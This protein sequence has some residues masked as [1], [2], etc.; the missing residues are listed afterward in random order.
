MMDMGGDLFGGQHLELLALCRH[1]MQIYYMN[2]EIELM[3]SINVSSPL[4]PVYIIIGTY[5]V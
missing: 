4:L 3:D 2:F 1:F 5:I